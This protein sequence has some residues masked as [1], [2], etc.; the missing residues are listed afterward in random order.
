L[1]TLKNTK[2]VK[3]DHIEAVEDMKRV[4]TEGG[5]ICLMIMNEKV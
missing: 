3:E 2:N 1:R 5:V 4:V